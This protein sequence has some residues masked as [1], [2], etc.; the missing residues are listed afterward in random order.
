MFT[1]PVEDLGTVVRADRR[2]DA[3]ILG[4]RPNRIP[5]AMRG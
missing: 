1:G 3:L 4:V 2:S 5:L